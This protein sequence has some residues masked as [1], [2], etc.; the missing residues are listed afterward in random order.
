MANKPAVYVQ[1][2]GKFRSALKRADKTIAKEL[3]SEL[4]DVSRKVAAE[5]S[6]LAPR[7]TGKMADA[8]RGVAVGNKGLVRNPVFYS[9]FIEFGFHPRGGSTEVP[10]QNPIG[11]AIEHQ[12]DRIVDGVGDAVEKA[13]VRMGWH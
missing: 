9:R 1:D 2:L 10:G 5:A 13:A 7:R 6:A 8:Y 3:Q 11:R 4:R 12:E